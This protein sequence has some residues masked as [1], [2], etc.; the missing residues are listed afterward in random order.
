MSDARRQ[1][2]A[3]M[4]RG[5]NEILRVPGGAIPGV[6]APTIFMLGLSAVFGQA[7]QLRGYEGVDFRTFH[8]AGGPAPGRLSPRR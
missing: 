6:L 7:S 5:L 3:L 4:R 8:R 2:R 1:V